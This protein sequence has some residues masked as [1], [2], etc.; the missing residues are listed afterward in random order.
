MWLGFSILMFKN[1]LDHLVD[2]SMLARMQH[3]ETSSPL[4]CMIPVTVCV[5]ERK[6]VVRGLFDVGRESFGLGLPRITVHLSN[7]FSFFIKS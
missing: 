2:V 6:H 7:M 4:P 5:F 1:I 3:E